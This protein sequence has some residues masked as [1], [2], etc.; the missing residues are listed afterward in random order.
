MERRKPIIVGQAP[1]RSGDG[2]P[3]SGPSGKRL[4]ELAGVENLDELKKYFVLDNLIN[5]TMA[6]SYTGKGDVWDPRVGAIRAAEMKLSAKPHD[7]FILCGRNVW[8]AFNGWHAASYFYTDTFY[9]ED[10][11]PFTAHHFPHPSGINRFWNDE[12]KVQRARRFLK[13]WVTRDDR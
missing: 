1:A 9:N 6:K 3:F 5:E 7:V 2:T 12:L 10:G 11:L 13:Q 4:C 8:R